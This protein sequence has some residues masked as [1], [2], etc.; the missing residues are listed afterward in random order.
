MATS[1]SS[2]WARSTSTGAVPLYTT[3]LPGSCGLFDPN[4]VEQSAA[5]GFPAVDHADRQHERDPRFVSP[6]LPNH[7]WP[8]F[9]AVELGGALGLRHRVPRR[10]DGAEDRNESWDV[11]LEQWLP[12]LGLPREQWKGCCCRVGAASLFSGDVQAVQGPVGSRRD[13]LRRENA[14]SP[15]RSIHSRT[16][17]SNQG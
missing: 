17:C 14:A 7:W 11:T 8:C 16:T 5:H 3:L 12:T 15:T 1:S 13:G 9:R 4:A 2:T 6:I 10:Q